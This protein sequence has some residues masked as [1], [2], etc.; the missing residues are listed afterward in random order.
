MHIQQSYGRFGEL[1]RSAFSSAAAALIIFSSVHSCSQHFTESES[2]ATCDECRGMRVWKFP[3]TFM[4]WNE[5]FEN[6]ATTAMIIFLFVASSACFIYII[7]TKIIVMMTWLWRCSNTH[8]RMNFIFAWNRN[9]SYAFH[10]FSLA[11]ALVLA[12]AS[13]WSYS[14]SWFWSFVHS[15]V[16][17]HCCVRIKIFMACIAFGHTDHVY[18]GTQPSLRIRCCRMFLSNI[19]LGSARLGLVLFCAHICIPN[20]LHSW[21]ILYTHT[22]THEQKQHKTIQ[23]L[24]RCASTLNWYMF[25][26]KLKRK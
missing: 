14:S 19:Y 7:I 2:Q 23:T 4:K 26:H 18:S 8:A 9:S 6:N 20:R 16:C 3:A 1:F 22:H 5:M 24:S 11:L 17:I 15:F 25:T 21:W 10:T 13:S 12:S